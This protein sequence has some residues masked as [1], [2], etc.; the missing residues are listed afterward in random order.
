MIKM[1]QLD[2]FHC[3]WEISLNV[4]I[5]FIFQIGVY[6]LVGCI[7]YIILFWT[8]WDADIS[9][10]RKHFYSANLM[11]LYN[12]FLYL[13]FSLKFSFF[14]FYLWGMFKKDLV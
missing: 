3:L 13:A 11:Y 12:I 7:G 1:Y 9:F 4:L 2:L 5:Y 10:I 14:S 6:G 8:I